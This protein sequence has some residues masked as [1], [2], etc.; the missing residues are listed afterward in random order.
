MKLSK[1][2]L[3]VS[4]AALAFSALFFMSACKGKASQEKNSAITSNENKSNMVN[5][6]NSSPVA[7]VSNDN[8]QEKLGVVKATGK[9][10]GKVTAT[11][12]PVD[13][14]RQMQTDAKGYYNYTQT[15]PL[16]P[17]GQ[18]SM[19]DYIKSHVEY[20]EK[21]LDNDVGGTVTVMFTIDESGQVGNVQTT[22]DAI[23]YGLEEEA[24]RVIGG[25]P[26]WTPGMVNG[27]KVKAWYSIPLTYKIES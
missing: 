9:K 22:G 8:T 12:L 13:K 27:K 5:E 26:K 1:L 21:A 7:P 15:S 24:M 23:G 19:E 17:G 3:I 6:N 14:S 4:G 18:T 10:V 11:L 20:P 16:Y 25:M 2:N